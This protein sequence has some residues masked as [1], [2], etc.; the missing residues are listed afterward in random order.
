MDLAALAHLEPATLRSLLPAYLASFIE[1]PARAQVN[2]ARVSDLTTSWSDDACRGVVTWLGTLGAEHRVYPANPECRAL[3][4]TWCRDVVIEPEVHG[5]EH[6][7]S[8]MA[9][10]PTMMLGNHLSYFDANATD[11]ALAWSGHAEVADRLV[12]AAGPKVYQDVFR[13]VAAACINN[14]PVPQSTTL[15]HTEKLPPRELARKALAGVQ[16][17]KR[18]MQEGFVPLV[19]PEGSRSRDGHLQPFIRGVHRWLSAIDDLRVV[20]VALDGTERIMPVN[21]T[22]LSAG[23]LVLRFGAPL[24]VGVDGTSR[25]VLQLAHDALA[26]LLPPRLRPLGDPP[27]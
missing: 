12:A 5:I 24:H 8:A 23:P 2:Q 9:A 10:G 26:Q 4:R 1:D 3:N 6:L 22:K 19:Y 18:A 20:P 17:A 7:S 21:T 15:G 11:V 25:E 16:A 13:L 27:A 14:L